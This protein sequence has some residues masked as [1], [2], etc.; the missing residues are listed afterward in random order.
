MD[1]ELDFS[2][3]SLYLFL[4]CVNR[5][6]LFLV[7]IFTASSAVLPRR[8]G[9]CGGILLAD[10]L[11]DF[12]RDVFGDLERD[13]ERDFERFFERDFFADVFGDLERDLER[14]FERDLGASF[15]VEVGDK[16]TFKHFQQPQ[17]ARCGVP[18]LW[19]LLKLVNVFIYI[20]DDNIS[21]NV[22]FG[23]IN[24]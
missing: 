16:C 20:N 21:R 18:P 3:K 9:T 17:S 1:V 10:F 11:R 2:S 12:F 13:F 22:L 15:R 14:F 6:H 8:K 24:N 4:H 23:K 5:L 7:Q 19:I